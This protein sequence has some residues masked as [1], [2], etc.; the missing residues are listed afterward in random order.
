MD[1]IC[2]GFTETR[3]ADGET[4]QLCDAV[5]KH[6]EKRTGKNFSVFTAH[7]YRSQLVH[8]INFIIK[9]HVG[10]DEYIHILVFMTLPTEGG[11]HELHGLQEGKTEKDPIEPF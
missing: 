7:S 9:V 2:G 3:K 5:K 8:G 10:G 11:D 1:I 6:V 4:Q